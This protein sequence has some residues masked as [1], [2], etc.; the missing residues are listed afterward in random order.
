MENRLDRIFTGLDVLDVCNTLEVVFLFVYSI[1]LGMRF[2]A[3]G[4]SCLQ[5]SWVRFDFL[6]VMLGLMTTLV[7][8]AQSIR[9]E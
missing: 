5:S 7:M 2:F 3:H 4:L 8:R 1:E 9:R 6:L